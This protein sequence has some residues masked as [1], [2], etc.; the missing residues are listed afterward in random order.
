MSPVAKGLQFPNLDLARPDGTGLELYDLWKKEHC[1]LL[2]LPAADPD[3]LAFVSHWQDQARLFQWLNTRLICAFP[4]REA[5]PTPWPAP[6]YPPTMHSGPLPD[7]LEWGKAYVVSKNRTLTEVY[8]HP[9]ELSV[10]KVERDLLYW[11]ANH[12]MA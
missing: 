5:I 11:E 1:L 8:P 9:G 2:L 12:C 6:G 4:R 7:G 10:A 3:A